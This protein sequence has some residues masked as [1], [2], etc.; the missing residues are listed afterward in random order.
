MDWI[1]DNVWIVGSPDTVARKL[2]ELFELTGGWGTLQ[3]EV[4]DYMDDPDP[5]FESLER[6]VKEV[7]PQVKL[8]ET[9]ATPTS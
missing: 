9:A 4:H 3:V 5:W 2:N 6:L 8:P 7:A 1:C